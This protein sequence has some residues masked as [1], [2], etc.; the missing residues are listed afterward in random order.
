VAVPPTDDW[1]CHAVTNARRVRLAEVLVHHDPECREFYL[2]CLRGVPAGA[3]AGSGSSGSAALNYLSSHGM[4]AA[5]NSA[6]SIFNEASPLFKL[7]WNTEFKPVNRYSHDATLGVNHLDPSKVPPKFDLVKDYREMKRAS[8]CAHQQYLTKTG[9]NERRLELFSRNNPAL[10]YWLNLMEEDALFCGAVATSMP[11]AS[12]HEAG[13]GSAVARPRARPRAR[14][15]SPRGN[16][17]AGSDIE[18]PTS[19]RMASL[20]AMQM[21]KSVLECNHLDEATTAQMKLAFNAQA[22]EI[23]IS[24]LAPISLTAVDATQF[25]SPPQVE[26]P[27]GT[28][29]EHALL[30]PA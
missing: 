21:M 6:E 3:V 7:Y 14:A 19:K 28:S 1:Q 12:S 25:D 11:T 29:A 10:Y 9:A 17:A 2:R 18:S 13:V 20:T 27:P 24:I 26:T 22:R 16:A 30:P 8:G 23:A 15:A 5:T 4:V